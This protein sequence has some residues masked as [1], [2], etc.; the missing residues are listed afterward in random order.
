M[1]SILDLEIFVRIADEGSISAAARSLGLTAA[2]A[3]IA[4]KRLET[5]LGSRLLA[6]S[7]RSLRLTPEGRRYLDSVRLALAALEDGEQ[8]LRQQGQ[9]L[10]G[11]LQLSAPSDFGRNALL[12]WLDEF[13][14]QHP[15]LRL[16]LQ[17]NDRHADLFR[18]SVDVAL[19]FGVPG[20]SSLVALPILAAHRR[21]VCASPQYLARHGAPQ[22]PEDLARHSALLYLRDGQLYDL[23]RFSR[24]DQVREVQVRGDY[25]CDDGEVARRWALAGHGLV[26]KARLDVA[27][28][29]RAGRLVPL[30]TD[31]QG[32]PLPFNLLCP[33]RLQVS[34]RVRLLHG[35]LVQRCRELCP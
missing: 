19:R 26:Y 16:Q 6:R 14:G 2:A 30:L 34:E 3:S 10:C 7:T 12:P 27:E 29:L 32:E 17:L 31:W 21:V 25:S 22:V 13:K 4:L 5:R 1:S 15:Q 9:G 11:V 23:W 24:D 8:A 35:F 33:H 18:E 20:D 28:D